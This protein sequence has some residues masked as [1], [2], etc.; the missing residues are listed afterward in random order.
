MDCFSSAS[1]AKG[2]KFFT[3]KDVPCSFGVDFFYAKF[4]TRRQLLGVSRNWEN[5]SIGFAFEKSKGPRRNFDAC[6]AS[7]DPRFLLFSSQMGCIW[8]VGCRKYNVS[9]HALCVDL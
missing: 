2:E 7:L 4:V 9:G 5:L 3:R 8:L 6:V 1:N